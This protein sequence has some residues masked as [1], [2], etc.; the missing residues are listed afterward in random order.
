MEGVESITLKGLFNDSSSSDETS[1]YTV[2]L[3]FAEPQEV[4][5]GK[6]VFNVIVQD[7]KAVTGL[8][9]VEQTGGANRV[10]V[11]EGKGI[12]AKDG[13][14]KLEFV[15]DPESEFAPLICGVEVRLEGE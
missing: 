1:T 12:P 11:A 9:I 6:R 4:K 14:L 7:R 15:P 5:V 8:D 10:F 3:H 2:R 13:K